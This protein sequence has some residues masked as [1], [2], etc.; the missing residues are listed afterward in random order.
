MLTSIRN[1]IAAVSALCLLA[2]LAATL[3]YAT[4]ASHSTKDEVTALTTEQL[5][6]KAEFGLQAVARLEASR[7]SQ[8][9]GESLAVAKGIRQAAQTYIRE[10]DL[11]ALERQRFSRYLRG[12]L[13]ENRS[14]IGTYV[15]WEPNAVDRED[16]SH[17][18]ESHT[19]ENGQYAPYW[20]RSG[21]TLALRPLNLKNVFEATDPAG[22]YW[23]NCPLKEQRNCLVEPYTWEMQ[24]QQMVGTSITM[25]LMVDGRYY[26][27]A[28]V[29]LALAYIQ[30][31][32]SQA[33]SR[34]Y[35][36]SGEVL[37]LSSD[38]LVAG[39]SADPSMIGKKL[40]ADELTLFASQ[41]KSGGDLII[42]QDA[43]YISLAAIR[44]PEV[45]ESWGVVIRLPKSVVLAGV[46]ETEAVLADNF[47]AALTR[48]TLIGSVIAVLGV[49]L[50]GWLARGIA[51]PISLTASRVHELASSDGDL[52]RR[53]N[54]ER[55]DEVGDLANG[56]NAFVEKTHSIVK[57]IAAEMDSVEQTA[58]RTS[59]I[60]SQTHSRVQR[61][62]QEI[63]MVAAAMNQMSASA[64][65]VAQ[66]AADTSAAATDAKSAV[67]QGSSNVY[68]SV[69]SIRELATEM[70]QAGGIMDQ[71]AQDS[72]NIGKIVEVIRGISEQTN[73]L[74]LNAAIEAARAGEQ[75]RGFSVVADEVRNLASQTQNSTTE[76]QALIEQLQERSRQAQSAMENGQSYTSNCIERAENAAHHLD[77]V[78]DAISRINDMTSQIATAADEQSTV[79]ED[80][81]RSIVTI[82][83]TAD[84]LSVGAGEVNRESGRLF[85]LIKELENKLNRFRY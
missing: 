24:G 35:N 62:Q 32:A 70:T 34:L 29:D 81:S 25:P 78:V 20:S 26:G 18:G 4:I 17:K 22:A 76:I 2:A 13:A 75:G 47:S 33:A 19:F 56:V 67:E 57:D 27:M 74:A 79:S 6:Q 55:R 12:I 41:L 66:S 73:L 23:Y 44:L 58:N 21:D 42:Q 45:R 39:H 37:V 31:I 49:V 82:N 40:A 1:K 61:Q 53:L 77:S 8:R 80:I 46:A 71:L 50:L 16:A 63:E 52:T 10:N 51:A 3:I 43:S 38:G 69:D 59:E 85:D 28:G 5:G 54:L 60:S 83:D 14:V 68:H 72:E 36:G 84:E 9:L 48:Q 7:I 11:V 15:A 65:Q 30:E 64:T